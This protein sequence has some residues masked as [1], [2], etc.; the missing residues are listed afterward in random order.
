[1]VWT[2]GFG[3]LKYRTRCHAR[4]ATRIAH[5][6]VS[7]SRTLP[8]SAQRSRQIQLSH[9]RIHNAF[10]RARTHAGTGTHIITHTH[11]QTH[12]L[13]RACARARTNKHT[14]APSAA[15]IHT[16]THTHTLLRA[17][18]HTPAHSTRT[19]PHTRTLT[20]PRTHLRTHPDTHTRRLRSSGVTPTPPSLWRARWVLRVPLHRLTHSV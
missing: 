5:R 16:P 8:T 17:H 13:T 4:L 18:T 12:A 15:H 20:Y 3:R 10:V 9:A 19:H 6:R 7:T 2:S 1:M 11:T 14:E